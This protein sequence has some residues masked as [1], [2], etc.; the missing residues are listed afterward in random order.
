MDPSH[1]QYIL[2]KNSG[3]KTKRIQKNA[4]PPSYLGLALDQLLSQ[5]LLVDIAFPGFLCR[6][7]ALWYTAQPTRVF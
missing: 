5:A 4:D 6:F 1:V 7:W 2:Y 3:S